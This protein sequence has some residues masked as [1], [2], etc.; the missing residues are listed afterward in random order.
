MT[1]HIRTHLHTLIANMSSL[2]VVQATYYVRS[3][4]R[5]VKTYTSKDGALQKPR[6]VSLETCRCLNAFAA[7]SLSA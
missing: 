7:F 2:Y 1:Q 6:D 4:F 5:P 3:G